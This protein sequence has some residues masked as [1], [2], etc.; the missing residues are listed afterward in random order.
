MVS[1]RESDG[2]DWIGSVIEKCRPHVY[3]T[4]DCDIFDPALISATGAPAPGGL[5]W[6]QAD[7]FLK[8]LSGERYVVGF[9]ISE[10]AP[11]P[12]LLH[13]QYTIAKL[14]YRILGY[15]AANNILR[16]D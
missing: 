13:P 12:G 4:I 11:V 3:I 10:L 16:S 7:R 6:Q 1:A 14:I 8:R 9:D 15:C 2:Q 5:T